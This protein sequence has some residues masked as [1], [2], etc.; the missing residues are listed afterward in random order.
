MVKKETIESLE[1]DCCGDKGSNEYH[2]IEKDKM[3]ANYLAKVW[4]CYCAYCYK[5]EFLEAHEG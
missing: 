2:L 1:C 4:V 5:N 3:V